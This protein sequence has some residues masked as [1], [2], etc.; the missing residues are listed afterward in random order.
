MLWR[1]RHLATYDEAVAT[2][3]KKQATTSR[4]NGHAGDS[5]PTKV[6]LWIS[7]ANQPQPDAKKT[8][9]LRLVAQGPY[10]SIHLPQRGASRYWP[11]MPLGR[12]G[13]EYGGCSGCEAD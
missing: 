13:C 8:E 2:P 3:H 10:R 5:G 6:V 9:A 11:D 12:N 4:R 7:K 1:A